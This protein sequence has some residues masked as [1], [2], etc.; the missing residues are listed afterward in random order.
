MV[1]TI[2]VQSHQRGDTIHKHDLYAWLSGLQKH[3]RAL[4]IAAVSSYYLYTSLNVVL[5]FTESAIYIRILFSLH[6]L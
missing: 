6:E 1:T 5:N 3:T 4:H 2:G